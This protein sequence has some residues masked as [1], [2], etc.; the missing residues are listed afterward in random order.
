MKTLSVACCD[1]SP[2]GRAKALLQIGTV[3]KNGGRVVLFGFL[4]QGEVYDDGLVVD[5]GEEG[6]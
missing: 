5:G 1:S 3:S 4:R 6:V 2:K